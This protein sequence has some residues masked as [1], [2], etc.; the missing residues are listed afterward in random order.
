MSS[1]R[2]NSTIRLKAIPIIS[3]YSKFMAEYPLQQAGQAHKG[4]ITHSSLNNHTSHLLGEMTTILLLLNH[5]MLDL[6]RQCLCIS[7]DTI[8][9]EAMSNS[10]TGSSLTGSNLTAVNRELG[11][12]SGAF[13]I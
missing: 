10:R 8:S 13:R 6:L 3:F 11:G 9:S 7:V 1:R 5:Y 2:L 4:D 12:F